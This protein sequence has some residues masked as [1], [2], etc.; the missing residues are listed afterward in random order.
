MLN[1]VWKLLSRTPPR[2][3]HHGENQTGS[4]MLVLSP[5]SGLP[6]DSPSPNPKRRNINLSPGT[7]RGALGLP[8]GGNATTKKH[9]VHFGL[10]D[11][12]DSHTLLDPPQLHCTTIAAEAMVF[13]QPMLLDTTKTAYRSKKQVDLDRINKMKGL[14]LPLGMPMGPCQTI[15]QLHN[16]INN[17]AKN[18]TNGGGSFSV[19]RFSSNAPTK[20][21]PITV[22]SLSL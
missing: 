21:I 5:A 4:Q 15:D 11:D 6:L 20:C 17:W 2:R 8:T 7:S 22:V 9:I 13:S 10:H 16:L 19:K 3:N 14:E 1:T 18:P 12:I